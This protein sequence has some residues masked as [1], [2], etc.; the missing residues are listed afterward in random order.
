MVIHHFQLQRRLL[1]LT[2]GI[3]IAAGQ[4][5]GSGSVELLHRRGSGR[6]VHLSRTAGDPPAAFRCFGRSCGQAQ[7]IPFA[8]AQS[9]RIVFQEI[10]FAP[11]DFLFLPVTAVLERNGNRILAFG[12]RH[13]GIPV[14]RTEFG[15]RNR[16][17]NPNQSWIERSSFHAIR[18]HPAFGRGGNRAAVFQQPDRQ[19]RLLFRFRSLRLDPEKFQPVDHQRHRIA[20]VVPRQ[21]DAVFARRQIGSV[22]ERGHD[23]RA[24]SLQPSRAAEHIVHIHIDF[25]VLRIAGAVAQRE[26][27]FQ[28]TAFRKLRLILQRAAPPGGFSRSAG[29]LPATETA[30]KR[31][32]RQLRQLF[33][34]HHIKIGRRVLAEDERFFIVRKAIPVGVGPGRI[35][36]VLVDFVPVRKTVAV[37]VFILPVGAE[38]H[39]VR[40]DDAVAVGVA[41]PLQ[42]LKR[43][44]AETV[45]VVPDVIA[46]EGTAFKAG[47]F[48]VDLQ[49]GIALV[50]HIF[51]PERMDTGLQRNFRQVFLRRT[52]TIIFDHRNAVH[53]QTRRVVVA[54]EKFVFSGRRNFKEAGHH[55]ADM[56]AQAAG[57][58][59]AR[60]GGK[61]E[62]LHD[63]GLERLLFA[64]IGQIVPISFIVGDF[65]SRLTLAL[66]LLRQC[67]RRC[68]KGIRTEQEFLIVAESVAVGI[69]GRQGRG[70]AE[71]TVFPL[72]VGFL[73]PR[74]IR[75]HLKR[76]AAARFSPGG[77]DRRD[78]VRIGRIFRHHARNPGERLRCGGPDDRVAAVDFEVVERE[79]FRRRPVPR[80]RQCIRQLFRLQV[81]RCE[82]LFELQR[83]RRSG[84]SGGKRFAADSRKGVVNDL[85]PSR[86]EERADDPFPIRAAVHRGNQFEFVPMPA[87]DRQFLLPRRQLHSANIRETLA[88][89]RVVHSFTDIA[90]RQSSGG[91]T[92]CFAGN[93]QRNQIPGCNP[94]QQAVHGHPDFDGSQSV[95]DLH[96]RI[97]EFAVVVF[98]RQHD[99]EIP[100]IIVQDRN[101]GMEQTR[102]FGIDIFK[103]VEKAQQDI[104]LTGQ[105]PLDFLARTVRFQR[106]PLHRR[107]AGQRRVNRL[108]MIFH[109]TQ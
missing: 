19:L 63:I 103:E 43:L 83:Q 104:P 12:Q 33:K 109:E 96:G 29:L 44:L 58:D 47:P 59:F 24:E 18:R 62:I 85:F 4:R 65:G 106:L 3:G 70:V 100:V 49:L 88:D 5:I 76:R 7:R 64:E 45:G 73:L 80:K 54:H 46:V 13:I 26:H 36:V 41:L 67:F 82:R 71:I 52:G 32:S 74:E 11:A 105:S 14:P 95:A 72:E 35:G 39:F 2:G 97:E 22:E 61:T 38:L 8:D 102:R 101:I 68:Y 87:V 91:S 60:S 75:K 69:V 30:G 90:E 84:G 34:A 48:P 53:L 93:R 55:R 9:S 107:K 99:R 78:R 50:F 37:A 89:Q 86:E 79:S 92:G 27:Q 42:V 21:T 81:V 1:H 40:I 20:V 25:G 98:I 15:G 56:V 17:I 51:K 66:Q 31:S 10:G 6:T 57:Q 94:F 77:A 108:L 28:D 16:I 23:G